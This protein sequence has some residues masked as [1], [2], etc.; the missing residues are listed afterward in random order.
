MA[1]Y[2]F[3]IH[4]DIFYTEF[5]LEKFNKIAYYRFVLLLDFFLGLSIIV[6]N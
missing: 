2:R 1:Y 6:L 4:G 5:S 3:V